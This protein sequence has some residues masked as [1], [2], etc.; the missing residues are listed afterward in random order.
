MMLRTLRRL[1]IS[2]RST[3]VHAPT[4]S[5]GMPGGR[6]AMPLHRR[7]RGDLR[8]RLLGVGL[9]EDR[10][11]RGRP[12]DD[13]RELVGVAH[14]RLGHRV[15]REGL[16]ATPSRPRSTTKP[17]MCAARAAARPRLTESTSAAS[18]PSASPKATAA[19]MHRP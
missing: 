18:P 8:E 3:E 7:R 10:G 14:E 1:S 11:A 2:I 4:V 6:L 9:R 15:E 19:S 5:T 13:A 17:L 12:V 16:G